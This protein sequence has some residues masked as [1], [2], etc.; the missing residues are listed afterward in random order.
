LE[1]ILGGVVRDDLAE[2]TAGS[3][4]TKRERWP[5]IGTITR[6]GRRRESSLARVIGGKPRGKALGNRRTVCCDRLRHGK[7]AYGVA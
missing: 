5:G 2:L 4:Y 1:A 7:M 6:S 3:I